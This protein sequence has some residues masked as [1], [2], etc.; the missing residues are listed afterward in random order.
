MDFLFILALMAFLFIIA[1]MSNA[2]APQE[3][4]PDCPPHKWDYDATGFLSCT[5]CKRR[6]G[7]ETGYDK[8]Y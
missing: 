5:L 6:P 1:N 3:K 4:K 7:G 8:P 2:H